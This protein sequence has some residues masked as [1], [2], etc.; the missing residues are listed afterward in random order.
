LK[1][2]GNAVVRQQAAEAW[3]RLVGGEA[4]SVGR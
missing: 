4:G 2:L 1:A 3:R